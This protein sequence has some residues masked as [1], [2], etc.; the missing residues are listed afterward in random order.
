LISVCF[1]ASLHRVKQDRVEGSYIVVFKH[2]ISQ[3]T[4]SA[5]LKEIQ[6]IHNVTFQ[7]TYENALKGFAAPLDSDQL[8]AMLNHPRVDFVEED[9]VMR[10]YQNPG[11]GCV[12]GQ[13]GDNYPWGLQRISCED[14][15]LDGYYSTPD[16]SKRGADTTAYIIDTGV[17]VAHVEFEGRAVFG[18]KANA[19][20]SDTDA[21]GHGTHVA[22][23][24][25]GSRYGV[26]DAA[27]VVA[28][29]VL[30]DNGSGTTAT[31]IAGVNF[32][33]GHCQAQGRGGR[34]CANMSL[35]GG[36]SDALN[37]AC[38]NLVALG[39]VLV[40]AAGNNN[41]DAC[42]FSPAS[43]PDAISCAA[44]DADDVRASFSNWGTCCDVFAPGANVLGAWIG[45]PTASR[46]ISGTSMASPHVCGIACLLKAESP[47]MTP[48]EIKNHISE[49][50]ALERVT[51]NCGGACGLTP[52]IIAQNG[53]NRG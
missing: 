51:L 5:D 16:I 30:G 11:V 21:N 2:E 32:V 47:G 36:Y 39:V 25:A 45:S 10:A 19:A 44:L 27:D 17:Y 53:C 9:Q 26:A 23:T 49:H 50:G 15:N 22:S 42:S 1:S 29:K 46:T 20:W 6:D 34:C 13:Y 40:V 4:L 43:A 18:Y 24:V 8:A 7:Y 12:S 14:L 28:V 31:V 48:L 38:D 41:Q 3:E 33:P 52:N 37:Q 35:G